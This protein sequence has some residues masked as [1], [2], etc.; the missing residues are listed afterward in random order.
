M[1]YRGATN[2][3][4]QHHFC[5]YFSG[6][7]H[8]APDITVNQRAVLIRLV[9]HSDWKE[10]AKNDNNI[11]ASLR[12]ETTY[13]SFLMSN[14]AI[15]DNGRKIKNTSCRPVLSAIFLMPYKAIMIMAG[16]AATINLESLYANNKDE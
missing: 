8:S 7:E 9:S 5:F 16:K 13:H 6:W 10:K 14:K 12:F 2:V 3:S 11:S 15:K 1:V 4:I